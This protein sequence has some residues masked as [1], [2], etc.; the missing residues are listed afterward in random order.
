MPGNAKFGDKEIGG[1]SF[2]TSPYVS[3]SLKNSN[4]VLIRI[5]DNI[6]LSK[7]LGTR[8][9][10][11]NWIPQLDE[12]GN[13]VVDKI[14]VSANELNQIISNSIKD[15]KIS[16]NDLNEEID[17]NFNEIEKELDDGFDSIDK[18]LDPPKS[19]SR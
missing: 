4:Y 2:G 18:V 17:K 3:K 13:K 10:N 9:E 6:T 12:N 8:D 11:G 16:N 5:S 1:Y 7:D 15:F 19:K 14:K